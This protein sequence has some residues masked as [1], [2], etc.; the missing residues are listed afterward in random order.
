M[1]KARNKK[2][3][4]EVMKKLKLNF[5]PLEV[6]DKEDAEGILSFINEY[7]SDEY[8]LRN[9]DKAKGEFFYVK[10]FEEA[11][12]K[13]DNFENRVTIG[14][15]YRPYKN[16]VVLVGDI[17]V[18]KTKEDVLV[19]LTARSDKKATHRNIYEKPKYNFSRSLD[20]DVLWSINGFDKIIKYICDYNLFGAVVEFAVYSV[21]IGINHDNVVISEIRTGY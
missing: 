19:T 11:K 21:K 5:F 13:L 9:T 8:V 12:E 4:V 15:S 14:V 7:H 1:I 18:D 20:D 3:S 10:N 16:K 6:F 2:E 17:R